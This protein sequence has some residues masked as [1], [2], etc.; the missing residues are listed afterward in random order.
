MQILRLM[1]LIL[2][3]WYEKQVKYII[4]LLFFSLFN[5]CFKMPQSAKSKL[6]MIA[7]VRWI[8]I[9]FAAAILKPIQMHAQ[10]N[11][12]VFMNS[13]RGECPK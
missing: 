8:T 3:Y 5:S 6:K 11:V 1:R 12:L 13:N 9:Q 4:T 10:R 7:F 2:K